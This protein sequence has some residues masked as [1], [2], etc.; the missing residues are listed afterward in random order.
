MDDDDQVVARRLRDL[1]AR[2]PHALRRGA[3][4]GDSDAADLTMPDVAGE[5]APRRRVAFERNEGLRD[6]IRPIRKAIRDRKRIRR[7]RERSPSVACGVSRS[8]KS[9]DRLVQ[10]RCRPGGRMIPQGSTPA[11]GDRHGNRQES[12]FSA[13]VTASRSRSFRRRRVFSTRRRRS[14]RAEKPYRGGRRRRR[15]ADRVSRRSGS[16][17][18]R[19][20]RRAGIRRCQPGPAGASR[21]ATPRCSH[22]ARTPSGSAPPPQGRRLRRDGLQRDRPAAR[23]QHDLQLPAVLRPRRPADGPASQDH[24]DLHRTAVLGPGRRRRSAV[25]DTDIG[26]LGGLICGEHLMTL[27]RAAMIGLGEEIHV[28]VFPGAFA[29]HTGP[30]LEEWDAD[31][32]RSGGMPRCAHMRSRPARSWCPPAASSTTSDIPD[33]FPHKGKMNIRYARGGVRSS[34]RSAFR[35]PDR[36]K[37]RRSSTRELQAWMIKA[38]KAIIDTTGHYSRPDLVR[39]MVSD[40]APQPGRMSWRT[41]RR[42][43]IVTAPARG[44]RRPREVEPARVERLLQTTLSGLVPP[45]GAITKGLAITP[46]CRTATTSPAPRLNV[47][48]SSASPSI[49]AAS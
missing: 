16:P 43:K 20:G 24:A 8:I 25:F 45:T 15:R 27:V 21:F 7:C 37:D 14:T 48:C 36:S 47:A 33:E 5:S 3:N 38:W 12:P 32:S 42:W 31:H 28:A 11:Q 4:V 40:H 22:R 6:H 46:R 39:L 35:S 10:A 23:G 49:P 2:A 26:R 44:R 18:T 13:A 1:G 41:V 29:L 34:R 17:A 19:T 9:H 30:E